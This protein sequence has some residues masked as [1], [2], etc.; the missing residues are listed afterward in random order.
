M[1]ETDN[2]RLLKAAFFLRIALATAYLS[3]VA[4][5]FELWP[6]SMGGSN[7]QKFIEYTAELNPWAPHSL[8]PYLG[9]AATVAE[10]GLGIALFVGFRERLAGTLSCL[11]LLTFAV[12]MIVGTGLKSPFDYSV[13]T[14]SAASLTFAVIGRSAWSLDGLISKSFMSPTTSEVRNEIV[15]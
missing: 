9:L 10:A 7:W 3:S 4:S 6:E 5:R 13:F 14:A 12:S 11:L 15:A 1:T 2:A 8:A